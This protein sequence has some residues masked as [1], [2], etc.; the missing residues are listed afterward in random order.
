MA[1]SQ[2]RRQDFYTV[3]PTFIRKRVVRGQ[4]VEF[5]LPLFSGYIFVT[6]DLESR[7]QSIN[8]TRGVRRLI[9]GERLE[10]WALPEGE[11]VRLLEQCEDGPLRDVDKALAAFK[12]GDMLQILDGPFAGHVG[13]C[14]W[15]DDERVKVLINFMGR[16]ASLPLPY[17]AV[18][19]LS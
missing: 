4:V 10:P 16:S 18:R 17:G 3:C 6:F 19:A 13:E 7:W 12:P 2:L 5:A 14:E 8:G 11:A 15:S 1:L 9:C